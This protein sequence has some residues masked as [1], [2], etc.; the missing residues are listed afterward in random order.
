MG[1]NS[2]PHAAGRY[3]AE[4]TRT[5]P[6]YDQFH[7]QTIDLVRV[8]LPRVS[9]WL[10]TGCGTGSLVEQA[11][12]FFPGTRFLLADPS[13][14]ML[15]I[16]RGTFAGSSPERVCLLDAM[17][18]ERLAGNVPGTPQVITAIQCHHYGD[19]QARKAATDAC[20][21]LLESG[22]LYI[23]FENIRPDTE[24]GRE[25]GLDRWCAF[26]REAGRQDREVEEHRL[27][28][29]K[30]YFPITVTDHLDLLRASGFGVAEVFWLSHMQAGFYAIK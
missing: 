20:F 21:R 25:I 22:G 26:Q 18:T 8:V 28:F 9:V 24:R 12:P 27:R 19:E 2:T 13:I 10:D 29:G 17:A 6:F 16:A 23:T 5:I 4:V 14:A 30:S 3:D 11:L 7:S 15:D 1:D